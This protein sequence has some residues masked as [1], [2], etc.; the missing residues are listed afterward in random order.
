M[1]ILKKN[2]FLYLLLTCFTLSLG[3]CASKKVTAKSN[4]IAIEKN[5]KEKISDKNI[6]YIV[7]GKE[8]SSDFIKKVN[9]DQIESITVYKGEKDVA[10]F[11]G[12]KYDGVIIIKMKK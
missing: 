10:K 12:K 2:Y 1:K 7:D 9:P 8:V 4:E 6:L 11:T 5:K 3:G